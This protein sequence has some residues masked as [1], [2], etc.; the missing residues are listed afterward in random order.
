ML[1]NYIPLGVV[2]S[3]SSISDLWQCPFFHSLT[4]RVYYQ[5]FGFLFIWW[6][7]MKGSSDL[8]FLCYKGDYTSFPDI[9]DAFIFSFWWIVYPYPLSIFIVFYFSYL[10]KYILYFMD[11]RSWST[12]NFKYLYQFVIVFWFCL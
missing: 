3:Y 9:W 12:I 5:T 6:V 1:S 2:T 4:N 8:Y 10:L 11:V 7:K